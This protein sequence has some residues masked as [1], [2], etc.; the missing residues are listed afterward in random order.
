[1]ATISHAPAGQ[2]YR[3]VEHA[4]EC[5]LRDNAN[6]FPNTD[7][8]F[9]LP[10]QFRTEYPEPRD[11]TTGDIAKRIGPLSQRDENRFVG[12]GINAKAVSSV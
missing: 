1:M 7:S 4:G 11:E 6:G 10:P 8:S 3:G 5:T 9:M 12:K 2:T